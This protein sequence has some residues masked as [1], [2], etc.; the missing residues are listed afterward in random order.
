VARD[1]KG[2]FHWK[3]NLRDICANY[4]R[5]SEAISASAPFEKPALFIHSGVSG[6]IRDEDT[7]LI[8]QLF[9]QAQLQTIPQVGHWVHAEAPE[10][11]LAMV[12]N[13]L[14]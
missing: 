10:A 5:L 13:F 11:F 12:L 1:P 14:A 9:P 6:Y 3:I 4:G 8:H 2:G 7:A